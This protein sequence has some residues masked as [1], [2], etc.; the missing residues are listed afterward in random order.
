MSLVSKETVLKLDSVS[1]SA[2]LLLPLG[3]NCPKNISEESA[4]LHLVAAVA[5][6]KS[7]NI[8]VKAIYKSA[9]Q[10][11]N[12]NNTEQY[13]NSHREDLRLHPSS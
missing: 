10:I 13:D 6:Y 8:F 9:T 5:I 4:S 12:Q 7:V 1:S 3:Q 11:R 2:P